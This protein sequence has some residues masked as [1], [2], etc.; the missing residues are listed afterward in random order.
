[1][2]IKS[3]SKGR[4]RSSFGDIPSRD[5]AGEKLVVVAVDED[6]SGLVVFVRRCL[7][8]HPVTL[9]DV[10]HGEL[11]H[12]LFAPPKWLPSNRSLKCTVEE[13]QS[14]DVAGFASL[15]FL[16]DVNLVP[17]GQGRALIL[18]IEVRKCEADKVF[19]DVADIGHLLPCGGTF[20]V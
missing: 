18:A 15:S 9:L 19:I 7:Q 1:M 16:Q 12:P 11:Q 5:V 17:K 8:G 3:T 4:L 13:F 14:T 10:D 20:A 6:D 2:R